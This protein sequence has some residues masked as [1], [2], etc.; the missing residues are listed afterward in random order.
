MVRSLEQITMRKVYLRILPFAAL[1]YF[2]CY[3]DRINVGFAALTMNKEIGLDS[4]IYGM[5]AGAF[6]WGYVLFEV[7]SNIVLE[8]VGARLWIARIMITWGLISGAT[9]FVTGP[10]SFTVIRFLLGVAEAGLFPGFV[11]YF[12]YW[13]PDSYRGRIN[14]GF[15]LALPIAVAAGAPVSTALL[16]FDGLWGLRGW[17]CMYLFEAVPTVLIGV[18]VFFFLTDRPSKAHWLKDDERDWLQRRISGEQQQIAVQH[19]VG[20][21]RSFCDPKVILLSLNY[22]GIVTASLGMLLFLPT[23]IKELGISNMQVGWVT[24]IP[25]TCGAISMVFFGWLSDRLGERRWILFWTCV[26]S[27]VGLVIAGLTVGTWWSVVGFSIAAAGF[28]GTKGPFWS[29]PTMFLT[30]AAAASGIAWINSLGNLGGFFGPTM[31]GW[32]KTLSAPG[33]SGSVFALI[34]G[35]NGFA[36]GLFAL[37]ICALASAVISLFWLRIPRAMVAGEELAAAE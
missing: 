35:L 14:S 34:G 23:I 33:G 28:Y 3:L 27:A 12:T 24:M 16:G 8:K 25:Y 20:I 10:Y 31:V 18:V 21:L 30:G 11:L 5:A 17:Q 6:F 37:A 29:M 15:T 2:F 19:G 9:A 26:A 1:T 32:A 22:I 4:A 36:P 13:F 7:P